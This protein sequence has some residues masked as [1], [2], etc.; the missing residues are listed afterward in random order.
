M[1]GEKRFVPENQK[2]NPIAMLAIV[3]VIVSDTYNLAQFPNSNCLICC[4]FQCG[5]RAVMTKC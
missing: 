1:A 5:H 3:H 2:N 4:G